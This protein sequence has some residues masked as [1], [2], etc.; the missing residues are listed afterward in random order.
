MPHFS[1]YTLYYMIWYNNTTTHR[2]L[3]S[4][5]NF[6]KFLAKKGLSRWVRYCSFWPNLPDLL[7][8]GYPILFFPPPNIHHFFFC[9]F[10]YLILFLITTLFLSILN[11]LFCSFLLPTK[12]IIYCY[13]KF[14]THLW[15]YILCI[16]E[17]GVSTLLI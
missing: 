4:K 17:F 12:Y 2:R 1:P 10:L 16:N 9:L 7:F 8:L 15:I 3:L 6:I 5:N 11:A 13:N 14:L